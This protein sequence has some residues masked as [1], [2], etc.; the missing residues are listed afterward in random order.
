MG[1]HKLGQ[2]KLWQHRPG[3]DKLG[4]HKRDSEATAVPGRDHSAFCS[5]SQLCV[6]SR[7]FP[8]SETLKKSSFFIIHLPSFI[9]RFEFLLIS[10]ASFLSFF[11]CLQQANYKQF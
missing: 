9:R 6:C 10:L 3:R 11:F 2:Q 5:I 8:T 1:Q 7:H 4:E